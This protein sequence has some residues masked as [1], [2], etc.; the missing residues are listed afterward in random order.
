[1]L[2]VV[3]KVLFFTRA[4]L[5]ASCSTDALSRVAAVAVEQ[6]VAAG[7]VLFRAGDEPEALFIVVNGAI[8]LESA[9]GG[10]SVARAGEALLG[11]DVLGAVPLGASARAVAP[12]RLL[13]IA[14]VDLD[15]L[16]D[17]DGELARCLFASVIRA[18]RDQSASIAAT[19]R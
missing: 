5:T 12:T 2:S 14:K 8:A 4:S 7:E 3:D 16:F 6:E 19:A 9:R 11:L 13:R 1:M 15:A 10:S 18:A 17:E